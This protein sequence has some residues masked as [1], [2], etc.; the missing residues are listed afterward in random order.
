MKT[1]VKLNKF[2]SYLATMVMLL[3]MLLGFT[4]AVKAETVGGTCGDNATWAYDSTTKTLTIS[5]SG[6]MTNY[7]VG[8]RQWEDYINDIEN[9]VIESGI[10]EIGEYFKKLYKSEK[11][12]YSHYG[13]Q[14][15]TSSLLR[16]QRYYGGSY[17]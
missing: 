3:S 17:S 2:T 4:L 1:K 9:A 7:S 5:G 11:Y 12:Q 13:N 16:M 6:A 10:T 8:N 15:W 14:N